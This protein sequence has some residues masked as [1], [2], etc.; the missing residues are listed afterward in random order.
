MNDSGYRSCG[1]PPVVPRLGADFEAPP[2]PRVCAL[3]CPLS[4][5]EAGTYSWPVDASYSEPANAGAGSTAAAARNAPHPAR[6]P[7]RSMALR[8]VRWSLRETTTRSGGA[9]VRPGAAS[10]GGRGTVERG[11]WGGEAASGRRR[12]GPR[13]A[14]A[15]IPTGGSGGGG[16]AK[17]ATT[18]PAGRRSDAATTARANNVVG[19]LI[20]F[21]G[22]TERENDDAV[23]SCRFVEALSTIFFDSSARRPRCASSSSFVVVL[24]R[25]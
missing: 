20:S 11:R 24:S 23:V 6:A 17:A 8:G 1:F 4:I 15:R 18:A 14:A 22:D 2:T 25:I 7:R 13:C 19:S 9:E 21:C 5:F 12:R 16:G 10:G 3:P